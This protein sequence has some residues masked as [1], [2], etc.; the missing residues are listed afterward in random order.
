MLWDVIYQSWIISLMNEV[1]CGAN[2]TIGTLFA[3][4]NNH[5][6]Q[7]NTLLSRLQALFLG[8]TQV[9]PLKGSKLQFIR[10]FSAFLSSTLESPFLNCLKLAYKW[11][12]ASN[13][14]FNPNI[15]FAFVELFDKSL[16]GAGIVSMH[17]YNTGSGRIQ[18]SSFQQTSSNF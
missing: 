17:C 13:L 14:G 7:T 15:K 8:K 9:D 12:R 16:V 1:R 2:G 11:L 5:Q 3:H 10:L 18:Y 4:E 6:K